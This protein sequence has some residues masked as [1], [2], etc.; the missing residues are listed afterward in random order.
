MIQKSR[1][2]SIIVINIEIE[3]PTVRRLYPVLQTTLISSTCTQPPVYDIRV[4]DW[5]L[6][7]H[8][9]HEGYWVV[10]LRW[11]ELLFSLMLTAIDLIANILYLRSCPLVW[12]SSCPFWWFLYF[13]RRYRWGRVLFLVFIN[14]RV[15]AH[16]TISALFPQMSKRKGFRSSYPDSVPSVPSTTFR[17]HRTASNRL[18]GRTYVQQIQFTL[19]WR[20]ARVIMKDSL[21]I[22][23]DQQLHIPRTPPRLQKISKLQ[24]KIDPILTWLLVTAREIWIIADNIKLIQVS[25]MAYIAKDET[26]ILKALLARSRGISPLRLM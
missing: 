1:E 21:W 10:Q 2:R 25:F 7:N 5:N 16:L 18:G 3:A 15:R 17:V 14:V 22:N 6:D 12:V 19:T 11:W 20:I 9:T 4:S 8:Y 23:I 26:H 24:Q 13:V